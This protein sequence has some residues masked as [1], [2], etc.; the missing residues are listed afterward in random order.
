VQLL[1]GRSAAATAKSAFRS[2]V[3]P[4]DARRD[5]FAIAAAWASSPTKR[6]RAA[7]PLRSARGVRR[8]FR[9]RPPPG[10]SGL[11]GVRLS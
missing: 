1:G 2:A 8:R 7:A 9:G 3:R 5:E 6:C 10:S 4:R 11:R